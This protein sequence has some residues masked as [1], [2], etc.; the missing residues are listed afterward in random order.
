TQDKNKIRTTDEEKL[1]INDVQIDS[2]NINIKK[3]T[4]KNITNN[5]D[6][7]LI[8]SDDNN[9]AEI[10]KSNG[11]KVDNTDAYT[12]SKPIPIDKKFPDG[13]VFTVQ[14]GA[15]KNPVPN[16]TFK[17][18]T[19]VNG[20]QT[21][22][23]FIRYQAGMFDVYKEAN[24]AKNDL[25]KLG[26]KDAFVAVYKNN[27]RIPLNEALKEL[28]LSIESNSNSTT[29]I[30]NGN[31][32]PDVNKIFTENN[33]SNT[34]VINNF[35]SID[36]ITGVFYTLQIGLFSDNVRSQTYY[37]LSPIQLEPY[38]GNKYRYMAG[39]YNK[40]ERIRT[41]ALKVRQIGI[42]DAFI[43]AYLNGKRVTVS[44]IKNKENNPNFIFAEEKPIIFNNSE[45]NSNGSSKADST[46]INQANS[47]TNNN[48]IIFSNGVNKEP[49]ATPENGIKLSNEGITFKIQI[50][51]YS[52]AVPGSVTENWIKIKN[53]PIRNYTNQ[54]QLIIYTVGSFGDFQNAKK[55]LEQIKS[56]G[57]QDAFITIFK[58]GKRL[59]GNEAS[60]YTR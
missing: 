48:D 18:L 41:D 49:D 47:N 54:N 6:S 43:C 36:K 39:V 5:F 51:A 37:N 38:N 44:E 22:T 11:I 59:Y 60:Q 29:G 32:L 4:N 13:L 27:Q 8:K 57:V 10:V 12:D 2:S 50:G 58:D 30:T 23:G 35:T 33:K 40:L 7:A 20:T 15:F 25:V 26:F 53:W 3:S 45:V 56:I 28:N 9:K 16:S 42:S 21:S 34:S 31:N 52:K 17:G 1:Q 19:P 46:K 14:V 24:A 55:L